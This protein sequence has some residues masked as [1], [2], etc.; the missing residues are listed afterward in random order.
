MA[1][2]VELLLDPE[3]H[4]LLLDDWSALEA[5][6]LPNQG[7]HQ[8]FS[9]APHITLAAATRIDARYD[10]DLAAAAAG[11][12][13]TLVTAGLL[14]FP[15]RRKFVLARHVVAD[16]ALTALHRRVWFALEAVAEPVPT[17]VRGSWTPHITIAHGLTAE[18]LAAACVILKN[19]PVDR[20]GSGTVR[21][22]D[23]KN[24]QLVTLGGGGL[25]WPDDAA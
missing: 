14:V 13:L 11:P 5:E 2:S 23:A 22:W 21:R 12:A 3:S 17:T 4:D 25:V 6:D 24:Q 18:Q 19:R 1:D 15:T 9:N 16:V 7:R 8:S 20:L 10:A